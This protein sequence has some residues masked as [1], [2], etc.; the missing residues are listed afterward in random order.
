MG[1]G[2][3]EKIRKREITLKEFRPSDHDLLSVGKIRYSL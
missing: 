2:R 3:K 1:N